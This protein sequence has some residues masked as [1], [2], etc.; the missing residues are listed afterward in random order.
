MQEGIAI[1]RELGSPV[2]LAH[3]LS[4]LGETSYRLG[5]LATARAYL[6]E[7]MQLTAANELFAHLAIAVFHYASLLIAESEVKPAEAMPKRAQ[8]AEL[9]TLVQTHPATWQMYKTRAAQR[10]TN[11]T[12]TPP[13]I[14]QEKRT[15]REVAAEILQG[16]H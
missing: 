14:L 13:I 1:A 4:C 15:I 10:L 12:T 9:L 11:V 2:Y 6:I 16:R 5:D 7:S 3:L 8:A